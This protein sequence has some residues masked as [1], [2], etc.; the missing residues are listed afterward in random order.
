MGTH[1]SRP[2]RTAA[3]GWCAAVVVSALAAPVTA[4]DLLTGTVGAADTGMA[5]ADLASPRSPSG[6]QFANPAGLA[7][8]EKSSLSGGVGA[9]W[10]TGR[11]T[12]TVPDGYDQRNSVV[13]GIPEFAVLK[14][15]NGPWSFAVGMHGTVGTRYDYGASPKNDVDD[16]FFAEISIVAAPLS[17]SYRASE[18]LWLGAQVM[19][20]FGYF[21]S[22]FAIPAYTPGFDPVFRPRFKLTGPGL[23]AMAGVTWH[24]TDYLS[25][26]ASARPQGR[27]WMDGSSIAPSGSR[28]DT[29]LVVKVPAEASVGVTLR[30]RG[31]VTLAYSAR[32]IDASSLGKS[33]VKF[34][35]SSAFN[36]PFVPGAQD[37]W[38][39]AVGVEWVVRDE[40]ALRAGASHADHMVE[41]SGLSPLSYDGDDTRFYAGLGFRR[42]RWNFDFAAVYKLP[43]TRRV[44]PDDALVFPGKYRTGDGV[45]VLFSLSREA[46]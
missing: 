15:G 17:L 5:G 2:W 31:N 18:R 45:L 27:V 21:R 19:P 8:F 33:D 13:V 36:F 3:A 34:E 10:G 26:A 20:L 28:Q 38:R 46:G 44:S 35:E 4:S 41:N 32:W 14:R 42:E 25:L 37:E 9:A 7:G 24:A 11:I 12:A 1:P 30:P 40:L 6:A 22:H 16:S 23:S 43:D 39:H 29:D